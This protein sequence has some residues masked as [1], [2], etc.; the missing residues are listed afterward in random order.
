MNQFSSLNKLGGLESEGD[1]DDD[2][3][4]EGG[5]RICEGNKTT[6]LAAHMNHDLLCAVSYN[7]VT[8]FE[9]SKRDKIL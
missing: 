3:V 6:F 4:S 2:I 7:G 1:N 8:F 5:T 9:N